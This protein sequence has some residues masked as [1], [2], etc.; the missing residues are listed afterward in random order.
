MVQL[1]IVR[2]LERDSVKSERLSAQLRWHVPCTSGVTGLAQLLE[3]DIAST[4][5]G[6][7]AGSGSSRSQE[8]GEVKLT[9]R[10]Q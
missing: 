10:T 7:S 2:S 8:L 6:V 5:P 1:I 3:R 4:S 9:V